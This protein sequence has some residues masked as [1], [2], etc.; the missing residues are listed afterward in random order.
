[1]NNVVRVT[2]Q[3]LAA[4]LGGTQSLHT[5]ALD[6]ALA[7]PT[8]DTA[9]LALRTQQVLAFETH[10][11]DTADP[12]GG[13]YLVEH[14]TARIMEKAEALM[15]WV[16]EHGGMVKA[17]EDGLINRR[18]DEA[19]YRQSR[20]VDAGIRKIVGVNV[21]QEPQSRSDNTL[22]VSEDVQRQ[23][24]AALERFKAARDQSQVAA[25]LGRVSEAAKGGQGIMETIVDAVQAGA[26]LG[27]VTA[28][29]E[30]VYGRYR[31]R[32]RI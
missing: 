2:I 29:L 24:R 20:Q 3:A 6:E 32:T 22:K 25:A 8:E 15:A 9:R 30:S 27:E 11:A 12:L 14:L 21:F 18:I 26:S 7:L 19:A 31:P 17:I 23:Q 28:A 4:I 13:S 16:E 1:M 10:V 5:N